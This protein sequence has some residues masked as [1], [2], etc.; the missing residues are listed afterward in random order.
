MNVKK[1][2]ERSSS[3]NTAENFSDNA[4]RNYTE[5]S[6]GRHKEKVI[7]C[8]EWTCEGKQEAKD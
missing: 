7:P 1:V 6:N 5:I 8:Q 3:L 4:N 2:S